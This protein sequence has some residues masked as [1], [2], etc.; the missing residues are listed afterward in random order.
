MNLLI[1]TLFFFF[2]ILAHSIQ[3]NNKTM[4]KNDTERYFAVETARGY[5]VINRE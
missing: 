5:I 2:V 3:K 4:N 1:Y